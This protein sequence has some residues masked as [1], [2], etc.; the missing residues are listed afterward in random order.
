MQRIADD[1]DG[2][3]RFRRVRLAEAGDIV[4]RVGKSQH[5]EI[6]AGIG[7]DDLHGDLGAGT[8]DLH[9]AAALDDVVVRDDVADMADDEPRAA[10]RRL[11]RGG[12]AAGIIRRSG[13]AGA[14][15]AEFEPR[16]DRLPR[17]GGVPCRSDL[18]A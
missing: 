15:D 2:L 18:R 17:I 11:G 14:Q 1:K 12:V 6:A 10:A 16:P 7:C 13:R 3:A 5:R 4:G 9:L 8:L